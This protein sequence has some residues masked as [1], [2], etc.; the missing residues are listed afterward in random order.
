M[1]KAVIALVLVILMVIPLTAQAAEEAGNFTISPFIGGMTFDGSQDLD[2]AL[3]FGIRGGYNF[4]NNLVLEGMFEYIDSET[5]EYRNTDLALEG[6]TRSVDV[7]RYGLDLLYQ[8][9]PEKRLIPFLTI[10]AGGMTLNGPSNP[11]DLDE[12]N[13]AVNFGGGLKYYLT[14]RL[15][16]RGDVRDVVRFA[17]DTTH[18]LEYTLGISYLFG[19]KEKVK[20]PVAEAAPV[21]N[22]DCD[23]VPDSVDTCPNT[24][25]GCEV[26]A[27]GCPMD[28]DKDGVCDGLDK[29]PGTPAGC[30]VDK[31]GCPVD[32]DK[33]GVC[34][35]RDKCPGTPVGATVDENG[36]PF[37]TDKDGV[38]DGIDKCPGTPVGCIVDKDG[39]PIDSDKDGVCDG[40]DKCPGTPAG[41]KV[42]EYGCPQFT[43]TTMTLDVK[44]DTNKTTIKKEFQDDLKKLAE[45]MKA[46]PD[47]RTTVEGH[48]DSVGSDKSNMALSQR[49]AEAVKKALVDQYGIAPERLTTV[50]YGE[51]KPIASNKTPAGRYQNRMVRAVIEKVVPKQK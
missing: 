28:A 37:D 31:D 39:C 9:M 49:R 42:D 32:E 15:A 43:K 26:D 47:T 12:T 6:R 1:K 21:V 20:A 36:C 3:L 2:T 27:N 44:F 7:Y 18:N 46:Y 29:C 41:T 30:V 5:D 13:F 33:D 25:C 16:L 24:P 40:R 19:L 35:G 34:D 11:D 50:G 22:S 38:F 17:S 10:G 8:F 51:T 4:T 23:N 45:F 48:T 14:E